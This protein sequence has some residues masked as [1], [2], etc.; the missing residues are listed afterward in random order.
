MIGFTEEERESMEIWLMLKSEYGGGKH[1]H[2]QQ[3][4]EGDDWE[5]QKDEI[6]FGS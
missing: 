4:K 3:H 6:F 5:W 2:M 1:N